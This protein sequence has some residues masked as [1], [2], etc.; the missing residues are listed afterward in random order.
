M[1]LNGDEEMYHLGKRFQVFES[2]LH[3]SMYESCLNDNKGK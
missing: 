3:Q 1:E 2:H